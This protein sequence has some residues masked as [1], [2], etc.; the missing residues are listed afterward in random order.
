MLKQVQHD[1]EEVDNDY[2]VKKEKTKIYAAPPENIHRY[3]MKLQKT[4]ELRYISHL[5]W[6]KLLYSSIRKAG[7]KINFTQGFNPGPKLSLAVALPLFIIGEGEYADMELQEDIPPEEIKKR[8]NEIL[9]ENSKILKIV[10]IS[11][12]EISI[13]KAVY[14]AK[15]TAFPIDPEKVEKINLK[16]IVKNHLLKDNIIIEKNSKKGLKKI[17]IRPAIHTLIVD[18][19]NGQYKLDFILKAGQ[20]ITSKKPD[21]TIEILSSTLRADDFLNFLTPEV[22]WN[23]VREKLL[24]FKLEELI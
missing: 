21:C 19:S 7:I 5:D 17:D 15:Y 2:S 10:K 23:V 18:E 20:E 6:Q 11:K 22:N 1:K 4:G 24:D 3:R 9:P 12:A 14:W 13:D 8:L 16:S